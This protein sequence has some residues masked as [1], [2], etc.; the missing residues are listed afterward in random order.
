MADEDYGDDDAFYYDDDDYL[1]VEDDYAIAVSYS[2]S[3]PPAPTHPFVFY[4]RP[5]TGSQVP[6]VCMCRPL[7]GLGFRVA[8]LGVLAAVARSHGRLP[9]SWK[10]E[11]AWQRYVLLTGSFLSFNRTNSPKPKSPPRLH[12]HLR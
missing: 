6:A 7:P 2:S 4:S 5:K 11:T 10:N 3:I 8:G 1:Y 9:F 12:G